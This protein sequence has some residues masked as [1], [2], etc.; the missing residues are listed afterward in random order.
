MIGSKAAA[1]LVFIAFALIVLVTSAADSFG[2]D[3]RSPQFTAPPPL[4]IISSD[5]RNQISS[6]PDSKARVRKTIELAE[7]HIQK[8]EDFTKQEKF[9]EA[10]A[11]L[12]KYQALL[13]DIFR[14]M[15]SLKQDSNKTRDLYKRIDLALRAEGPRLTLLRRGTP[16][17]YAVWIKELEEFTRS[18]RTQALNSFYGQTVVRENPT[19]KTDDKP[20]DKQ[21]KEALTPPENKQP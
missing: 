19:K 21:P 7:E 11:E 15:S 3:Q 8:A 9:T 5:E 4:K 14:F 13:E 1:W 12:G 17:E 18:S 6:I 16:L 2:Q 20:R 10:S